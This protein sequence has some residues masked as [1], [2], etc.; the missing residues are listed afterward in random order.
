MFPLGNR[1]Q[2]RYFN[3]PGDVNIYDAGIMYVCTLGQASTAE[4]GK[5]WVD[6]E[7]E[8]HIPQSIPIT[9]MSR[10][11]SFFEVPSV[12]LVDSA[13]TALVYTDIPPYMSTNPLGVVM[14]PGVAAF[15]L[16]L[17]AYRITIAWSV[18]SDPGNTSEI[19][20]NLNANNVQIPDTRVDTH[21]FHRCTLTLDYAIVVTDPT[22]HYSVKYHSVRTAGAVNFTTHP[23]QLLIHNV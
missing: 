19:L 9:P 14:Q 4:I 20:L 18:T 7:V 15:T 13:W 23:T 16:P 6:Y 22:V 2:I 21:N 10:D 17:G 5:L 11:L 12:V 1:K 8:F 3:V